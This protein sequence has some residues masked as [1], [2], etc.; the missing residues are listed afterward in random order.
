MRKQYVV[1]ILALALLACALPS[2]ALASATRVQSLG[3]QGDYI[4]DNSNV[5]TYPSAIVRYQNLIYG[6]LGVKND[7]DGNDDLS[8]FENNNENPRLDNADRG[9]GALLGN[10]EGGSA[11]VF[12]IFL[13]ENVVPLSPALGAQYF[14]RNANEALNLIWGYR[15]SSMAIGLE[16]NYSNSEIEQDPISISPYTSGVFPSLVVNN[17]RQAFNEA[18]AIL[19]STDWNTFGVGGGVSFD[20]G[21]DQ[22]NFVDVGAEYRGH[23]FEQADDTPGA[24]LRFEDDGG[25][26]FGINARARIRM[27]NTWLV[28]VVNYYS[29]DFSTQ[30]TDAAVPAND[31]A[32]ENTVTGFNV[33]LDSQWELRDGDWFHLG[34]AFQ[35]MT[36]D[37]EDV[38]FDPA[39]DGAVKFTYTTMPQIFGALESNLWSW[40]TLRLGASKPL[41][42]EFEIEDNT[43]GPPTVTTTTQDSPLQY[44]VGL[45]FHLGRIDLDA[46][47]NQ[48]FAFTGSWLASGNS[49]IPFTRLTATYRW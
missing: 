13:N 14:N 16:V 46:L 35:S 40:L 27:G 18:A 38:F 32:A 3:L 21:E 29:M 25:A 5:H 41:F 2:L 39:P 42:S 4:L 33:G 37:Y 45:G 17:A 26:A 6:D 49:E 7:E 24:E 34:I 11:G 20:F 12:G 19:G 36:M 43:A 15:L 22:A 31:V 1:R 28:P 10:I 23:S 48:D 44:A 9:L 8:N 30:F 47:M